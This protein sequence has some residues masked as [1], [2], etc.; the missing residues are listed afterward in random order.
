MNR[1][2]PEEH[3][4]REYLLDK[5]DDQEDLEL[6]RDILLGNVPAEM[7]DSIEDEIIE[8]YL[9]NALTSADKER[10]ERFLLSSERQEKLR[11]A[12][13]LRSHLEKKST[14]IKKGGGGL[15]GLGPV[16]ATPPIEHVVGW[17]FHL[18]T[19]CEIAALVLLT[20]ASLTYISAL[21]HQL[22]SNIETNQ[23]NQTQL[24]NQV[25]SLT[26][27]LHRQNTEKLYLPVFQNIT[28]R[29]GANTRKIKIGPNIQTI[30]VEIDVSPG[31]YDVHL[32]PKQGE[33]T[34][35][36]ARLQ[37]SQSGLIVETPAQAIDAGSNCLVVTPRQHD[38]AGSGQYCFWVE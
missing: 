18:R 24:E 30:H 3:T 2:F 23:K 11:H 17:G 6:S 8:D 29:D 15:S 10:V 38:A 19:Y 4:L 33:T 1:H 32:E 13:L 36:Q 21:R 37:A 27:E 25:A 26:A 14:M 9:D 7:I 35:S 28:L 5:L 34:W 31:V 22:R 12:R 20:A 16:M